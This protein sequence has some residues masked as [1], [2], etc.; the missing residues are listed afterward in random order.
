MLWYSAG[1]VMLTSRTGITTA[2]LRQSPGAGCTRLTSG[3]S[4]GVINFC[5]S[6]FAGSAPGF[7]RRVIHAV[8]HGP[9]TLITS[10]T[11]K[12]TGRF[13]QIQAILRAFATRVTAAKQPKNYGKIEQ[14]NGGDN[15]P[16]CR[17]YGRPGAWRVMRRRACW[18]PFRPPPRRQRVLVG[19]LK[20]AGPHPCEIF[21]PQGFWDGGA[22]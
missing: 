4:C 16:F 12:A 5:W 17:S 3:V 19:R 6:R 15:H 20:T 2:A 11:T 9:Q 18:D 22:G 21:S 14:K 13:F 10:W 8:G 7:T 1:T